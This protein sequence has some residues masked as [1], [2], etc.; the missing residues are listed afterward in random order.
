MSLFGSDTR[1]ESGTAS[2]APAAPSTSDCSAPSTFGDDEDK[3]A[4]APHSS[5]AVEEV[6][7]R[8]GARKRA[9]TRCVPV[10]SQA[11]SLW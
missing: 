6:V 8:P 9:P 3:E 10:K 5:S 7:F 11:T 2:A 4:E 1:C